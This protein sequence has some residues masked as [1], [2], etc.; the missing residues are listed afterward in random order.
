MVCLCLCLCVFCL[1]YLSRF[2]HT[3]VHTNTCNHTYAQY[4]AKL[5]REP[6]T[7][8]DFLGTAGTGNKQD[9]DPDDH[10]PQPMVGGV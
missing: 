7:L 9:D 10:H 8:G 1:T 4:S 2:L 3:P 6:V 5:L